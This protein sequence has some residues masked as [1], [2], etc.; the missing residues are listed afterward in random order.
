MTLAPLPGGAA[1]AARQAAGHFR[2]E[3]LPLF[4]AHI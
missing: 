4:I 2:D 1:F 3:E